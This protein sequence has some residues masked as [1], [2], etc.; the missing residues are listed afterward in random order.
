MHE[1]IFL[2]EKSRADTDWVIFCKV[3]WVGE[4]KDKI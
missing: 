2:A 3:Y 1:N 4:T